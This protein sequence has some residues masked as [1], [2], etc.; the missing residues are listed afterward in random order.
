MGA[1]I[2]AVI[3]LLALQQGHEA[4][5]CQCSQGDR[6]A[7]VDREGQEVQRVQLGLDHPDEWNR[8]FFFKNRKE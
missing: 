8:N 2:C 7:Q 4:R 5:P 6:G 1:L 3:L